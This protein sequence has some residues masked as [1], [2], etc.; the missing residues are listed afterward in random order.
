MANT[1]G[2]VRELLSSEDVVPLRKTVAAAGG[3]PLAIVFT[4]NLVRQL[5]AAILGVFAPNLKRYFGIDNKTLGTLVGVEVLLMILASVPVGYL[6][7]RLNRAKVLRWAAGAWSVIGF[8]TAFAVRLIPFFGMRVAAGVAKGAVD[9]VGKSLLTDTYPVD[10]WNRVLAIETSAV[11]LANLIGPAI[12]GLLGLFMHGD[13]IWRV[14]FPVLTL[15]SLVALVVSRRLNEPKSQI[16]RTVEASEFKVEGAASDLGLRQAIT[17]LLRIPTFKRQL[18]GIGVLGFAL[19]GWAV[20]ASVLYEDAFHIGEAGRGFIAAFLASASLVGTLVGGRVGEKVFKRSARNATYLVGGGIAAYSVV[21]SL[22]VFL[23]SIWLFVP[24]A[25][26]ATFCVGAAS[27]PLYAILSAISPPRLRPLMF[28]LLGLFV[29]LFGGVAAGAIVGSV[30]DAWGIRVAFAFLGPMGLMGGLL[31]ARGG[32]TIDADIAHVEREFRQSQEPIKGPSGRDLALRVRSLNF[33]YDQLQVLF[34]VD[35][36]VE[37]GEIVALLGTNGAGKSTLLRAVCGLEKPMRGSVHFFGKD[38]TWEEAENKVRLG[39]SQVP[40]GR[41]TFPSLTVLENLRTGGYTFR[42]DRARVE[43]GIEEVFSYFPVL[44][45]RKSQLA[46]TLSGGEQQMLALG[47]AFIAHPK[48]LLIDELSLGLA[49]VILEQL[50]GI[51]EAFRDRGT[52]LLLV[53]Q[54]VNVALSIA[55]TA[56]FMERGQIRFGGPA[57]DLLERDDL[58]RSVFLQ[59]AETHLAGGA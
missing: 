24:V 25:W 20:F 3:Y 50:I 38:V 51:V 47:R 40:G 17:R 14:A 43:R 15:P 56:Y 29:A 7:V 8:A 6:G 26:V 18:V 53:E 30:A 39:M 33:A 52:T 54:S 35:L 31:M 27:A 36:D 21:L 49:P 10:T 32:S 12:A 44:E 4:L 22:A 34:D 13:G 2:R 48:L 37:E 19:I 11:P 23:P 57:A 41:A 55:T 5:D 1:L 16:V 46:G 9:P 45:Q 42:R 58:L 28:A 59:G